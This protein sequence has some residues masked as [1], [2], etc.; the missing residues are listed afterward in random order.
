MT[1]NINNINGRFFKIKLK[2]KII[3]LTGPKGTF[4]LCCK[5]K[6]MAKMIVSIDYVVAVV[7]VKTKDSRTVIN[8]NEYVYKVLDRK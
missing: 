3:L 7:D 6:K 1:V 4:V 2:T 5:T 8:Y